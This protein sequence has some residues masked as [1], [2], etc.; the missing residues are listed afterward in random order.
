MNGAIP[1]GY[2][3]SLIVQ[4]EID[5]NNLKKSFEK[6]KTNSNNKKLILELCQDYSFLLQD[7]NYIEKFKQNISGL[8]LPISVRFLKYLSEI[9]IVLTQFKE[10]LTSI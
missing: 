7:I 5:F 4:A 6:L 1:L 8:N 9:K 2:Y 3:E 10:L